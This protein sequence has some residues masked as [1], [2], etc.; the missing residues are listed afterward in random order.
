MSLPSIPGVP[1]IPRFNGKDKPDGQPNIHSFL[2]VKSNK[3]GGVIPRDNECYL[4]LRLRCIHMSLDKYVQSY[5]DLRQ[6]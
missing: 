6:F 2:I 5:F 3:L 4:G 1:E